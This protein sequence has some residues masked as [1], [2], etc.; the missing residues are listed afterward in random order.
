MLLVGIILSTVTLTHI[1]LASHFW[2]IGIQ[3]R[4]RSD[5]A[6]RR[7]RGLIKV[8]AVCT[9]DFLSKVE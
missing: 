4:L 9:Q 8:Y 2:D 1:S 6:E 3:C 7:T 5:A